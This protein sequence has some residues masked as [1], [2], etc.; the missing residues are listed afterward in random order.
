MCR[1]NSALRQ[2]S[3][4]A[5][6]RQ[7]LPGDK[8]GERRKK[9]S[10]EKT[11]T[12]SL[13]FPIGEPCEFFAS[14]S[15]KK[16]EEKTKNRTFPRRRT[17]PRIPQAEPAPP[18][19]GDAGFGGG[20]TPPTPQPENKTNKI[21]QISQE[22]REGGCDDEG[23]AGEFEGIGF[24]LRRKIPARTPRGRLIWGRLECS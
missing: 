21:K 20:G 8:P 23:D 13:F 3:A 9:G 18:C 4:N 11:A 2:C 14:L 24:S 22:K 10:G 7:L 16:R 17:K 1:V 19:Y 12:R 5:F 15:A 6:P